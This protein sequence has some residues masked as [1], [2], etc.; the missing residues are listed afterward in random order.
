[1]EMMRRSSSSSSS[2]TTAVMIILLLQIIC[3]LISSSIITIPSATA[4]GFSCTTNSSSSAITC[5][6]MIDYVVSPTNRSL[7]D[8]A[9][10]FGVSF[11]SIVGA[12]SL[13]LS[14]SPYKT[15]EVNQTIKIPFQCTCTFN[16]YHGMSENAPIY[17]VNPGDSLPYIANEVFSGLVP[18]QEIAS[19]NGISNPD[20]ILVAIKL[21]I[22][23]P[24]SC[25]TVGGDQVVHY[26]HVVS[27]EEG[28]SVSVGQIA[29]EY[30]TTTATLLQLNGL[31]PNQTQ[32]PAGQLIDVPLRACKSMV[33][34][35]SLDYPLLV[36]NG[37]TVSTANNCVQ[38]TCESSN[39]WTLH[40]EPF[41]GSTSTW[42][43]S[44]QC[45]GGLNL[46]SSTMSPCTTC[47]YAGFTNETILKT[48]TNTCSADAEVASNGN[49][50]DIAIGNI[51]LLYL[52]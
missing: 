23:L 36:P 7:A 37:T 48:L 22:P 35:N 33:G 49:N 14:T 4:L 28:S 16:S 40:C 31:L 18:Y 38:C 11:F 43:S 5:L 9:N 42:C 46:G 17:T 25:D 26:A 15:V 20:M 2:S 41:Q 12:N 30:G 21:W 1:M 13:P 10:L 50:S 45:Q 51:S 27:K 6:A 32:L 29:Q 44:M 24:C 3:F 52:H 34:N 19:V 8:I 47:S 39:N